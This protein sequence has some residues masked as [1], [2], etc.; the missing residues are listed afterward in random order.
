[1]LEASCEYHTTRATA[2]FQSCTIRGH[3]ETLSGEY[4]ILVL[5]LLIGS[6]KPPGDF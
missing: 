5:N 3:T 4:N 6:Q 2:L 1:M